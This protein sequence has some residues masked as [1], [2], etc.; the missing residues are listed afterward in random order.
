MPNATN[1]GVNLV[2]ALELDRN[3]NVSKKTMKLDREAQLTNS[4]LQ[5]LYPGIHVATV[6]VPTEHLESCEQAMVE[7]EL[8]RIEIDGIRYSLVGA[9]GSGKNGQFYAVDRYRSSDLLNPWTPASR[10][11][12]SR[13]LPESRLMA[14]AT[15]WLG[16]AAA[17]RT[18]SST[19]S[20]V[21]SKRSLRRDFAS[22]RRP[23]SPTSESWC[24][25]ARSSS[26]SQN[27]VSWLSMTMNSAPTIAGAGS[28]SR[29]SGKSSKSISQRF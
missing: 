15:A 11:W 7:Q 2:L 6:D 29:C 18:V 1:C 5:G 8:T 3:G 9:S 25:R 24:P 12:L 22:R 21:P 17:Q 4:L 16:L 28:R 10:P 19:R 14:F 13:H 23:P 20:R 26:R 27:A